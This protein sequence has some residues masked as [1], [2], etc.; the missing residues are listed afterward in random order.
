M[1]K[2]QRE[3]EEESEESSEPGR[4]P[5]LPL[6]PPP[7]SILAWKGPMLHRTFQRPWGP[8]KTAR[9]V[10]EMGM[11]RK[12]WTSGG[13]RKDRMPAIESVPMQ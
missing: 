9:K 7:T 2:E 12:A 8:V 1:G 4:P 6:P 10:L 5:P 3:G 11:V 13:A